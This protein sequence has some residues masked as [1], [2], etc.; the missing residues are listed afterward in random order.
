MRYRAAGLVV[1]ITEEFMSKLNSLEY[2]C[3]SLHLLQFSGLQ[4][5]LRD[6][7]YPND[8]RPKMTKLQRRSLNSRMFSFDG[9]TQPKKSSTV[10]S[11]KIL[12]VLAF[13]HVKLQMNTIRRENGMKEN[14][15]EKLIGLETIFNLC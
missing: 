7:F 13:L 15:I 14:R 11:T 8:C 6:I 10:L 3:F 5:S 4:R 9:Q 1:D 12:V 2:S